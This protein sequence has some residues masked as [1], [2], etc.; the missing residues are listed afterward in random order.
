MDSNLKPDAMQSGRAMPREYYFSPEIFE[1]EMQRI[2]HRQWLLVGHVSSIQAPGDY[3]VKQVG[4]ESL[5]VTRD[6][7]GKP[8]AFFNMCRH[9][10]YRLL[11]ADARGCT[12]GFVCPYHRWSYDNRGKL[13]RVPGTTDGRDFAFADWSLEEAEI[14]VWH[15]FLYAR[16]GREGGPSLAETLAP[17]TDSPRIE[18]FAPER[19]KLAHRETY[20]ID[21]NWKAMMENDL[22]CYH[23]GHGGHPS[24]AV[25]CDFRSFFAD[26]AAERAAR[27]EEG[28][29]PLRGGMKTFSM[30][31]ERVC[32]L[33]LGEARDG[34]SAGFL[35]WPLF[36]GPVFFVD[37]A[38]SLELTPLSVGQS[39]FVCEWYVHE[40]AVEGVDYDRQRLVE[41]F[42]VTNT[43]DKAFG[44]RNY[45]GMRSSRFSPGP[46]H[47]RR[48][49]GVIAGYEAYRAMMAED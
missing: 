36:N 14:D 9:R 4:P 42:H 26:H 22:E 19:L 49:D 5:I 44:E 8:R 35:L 38:V 2:V 48:E 29:F 15:G 17:M 7:D 40:D 12:Q 47:P 10:G 39:H 34:D 3:F 37:H 46:L 31:G 6:R 11:D 20:V 21:A 16:L 30:D 43:E 23:C 32:T 45:A 18:R 33:P 13:V 24:L 1:R 27:G 41:V 28:H 25:A